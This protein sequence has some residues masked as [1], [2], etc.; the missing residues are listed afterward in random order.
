MSSVINSTFSICV[1]KIKWLYGDKWWDVQ[2]MTKSD[3]NILFQTHS[4]LK[5]VTL[6][7]LKNVGNAERSEVFQ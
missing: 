6:V 2:W 3:I 7:N 5:M 4:R 1:T